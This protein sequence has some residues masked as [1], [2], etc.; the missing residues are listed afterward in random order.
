[1]HIVRPILS[2]VL[3]TCTCS[4]GVWSC[5]T[6]NTH[7]HTTLPNCIKRDRSGRAGFHCTRRWTC[8]AG[9][10]C[11]T[12]GSCFRSSMCLARRAW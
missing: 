12:L 3:N 4:I 1:M 8:V 9:C 10:V 5:P 11:V 2:A 7:H 6:I